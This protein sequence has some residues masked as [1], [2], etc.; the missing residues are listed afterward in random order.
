LINY[1]FS[2]FIL[3]RKCLLI[4]FAKC[5]QVVK[6]TVKQLIIRVIDED[7]RVLVKESLED[8]KQCL[9]AVTQVADDLVNLVSLACLLLQ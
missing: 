2:Y 1:R 6:D 7:I 5:L 3:D 9:M 8:E 4:V